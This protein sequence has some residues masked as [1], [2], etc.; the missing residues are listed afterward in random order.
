MTGG[1]G[2][3]KVLNVVMYLWRGAQKVE[4][5]SSLE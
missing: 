3:A 4:G 5:E 1:R 2:Q